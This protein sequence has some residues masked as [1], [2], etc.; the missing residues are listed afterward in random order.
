M[1][2][3]RDQAAL[4]LFEQ[5]VELTPDAQRDYL[6]REVTS[7][8]LREQVAQMLAADRREA[9][10]LDLPATDHAAQLLDLHTEAPLP[11]A[12]GSYRIE[13]R[14]GV[15]GMAVVYRAQRD[16]GA[17]DQTVALK[18]IQPHRVSA[19]WRER[20]LQERQILASL[21]HPNIARLLDG[22]VAEDGSPYFVLEFVAGK[23]IHEYCDSHRLN[24]R[25]RLQL[26]L[27]VCDAVSHAH[28]NLV[29]H[30]DLKPSNILVNTEGEVKLLDFGIAK[31]LSGQAET[32]TMTDQRPLTPEYAAPEQYAGEAI[33][34]ATDSY[35]LGVLLYELLLGSRPF[36]GESALALEQR[37]SGRPPRSI[38]R[39]AADT[40]EED[41]ESIAAARQ[42]TWSRLRRQVQGDLETIV[43]KALRREPERRYQSA[44]GLA[45]D[46]RRYLSG[47]PVQARRASARYRLGKFVS[48]H[49]VGTALAAGLTLALLASLGVALQ[50]TIQARAEAL[51]ANQTRDFVVSLFEY[52]SPDKNPGDRLTARQLLN[53]GAARI[54]QELGDEPEL[55]SDMLVVMAETFLQLG[56]YD[57]AQTL[58]EEAVALRDASPDLRRRQEARLILARARRQSG[59]LPGAEALLNDDVLENTAGQL[60]AALLV[61]RG[62]LARDQARYDDAATA[63]EAALALDRAQGAPPADVARDLYQ[64][65]SLKVLT[66]ENDQS[67]ELMREA[68]NLASQAQGPG[69]TLFATI[70]HDLGVLLIQR[71]ELEEAKR[72]LSEVRTLRRQLLGEQHPDY[73]ATLKELAG[74][75][76]LNGDSEAAEPL[77]LE[78]LEITKAALGVDHSETANLH[79]SLAVFYRGQGANRKA[80]PFALAALAGARSNLGEE[81]PTV[82]VMTANA[83]DLQRSVG[84]LEKASELA[85]RALA[86]QL[87]TVGEEHHLTAVVRNA[88][89]A[90]QFDLGD[91]AGAEDQ[92]RSAARVFRQTAGP[93]HPHL[94]N[95]E[96]SLARVLLTRGKLDDAG[97]RYQ[98]ALDIAAK[99]LPEGHATTA[100][101]ALGLAHV[102]ASRGQCD[103]AAELA[104]EPL[105]VLNS[106]PASR[107]DVWEP[108][109]QDI[110]ACK[111]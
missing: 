15:G 31:L 71:G 11:E 60:R 54:E 100:V 19:H 95:I 101:A 83:A 44:D 12:I 85:H 38:S 3:E 87:A 64:L 41:R 16:D 77:Y 53:L 62:E 110:A 17:F 57:R 82:G 104:E 52:A 24:L 75:A 67:L 84:E 10:L 27:A 88:L 50:Q 56:I 5:L 80:L 111:G 74:I 33:T 39:L 78:A 90:V 48:R 72:V 102:A 68:G 32:L 96:N 103:T 55:K 25:E 2:S 18:V 97:S 37:L 76:R 79:N 8:E 81:H 65:A 23:P 35:A 61:E 28:R 14:L 6:D 20:F 58:A 30:R 51:R 21:E 107:R 45:D 59:D 105:A 73:G 36:A 108:A 40:S 42:L 43:Q 4:A 93:D 13:D 34:T 49:R 92:L 99:A 63:F 69:A 26:L 89:A 46:L 70:Q 91:F 109:A 94:A 47:L 98:V 7:P 22:G 86:I 1:N 9:G 106:Q 29:V 66:G